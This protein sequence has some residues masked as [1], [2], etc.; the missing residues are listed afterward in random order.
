MADFSGLRQL[1]FSFNRLTDFKP[2][3]SLAGLEGLALDANR[4]EH[5]P[6]A[7]PRLKNLKY[8]SLQS[9]QLTSFSGAGFTGLVWL[10]LESNQLEKL[11]HL[12]A[13]PA[14]SELNISNNRL[15]HLPGLAGLRRLRELDASGNQLTKIGPELESLTALQDLDL[16]RNQLEEFPPA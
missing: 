12:E 1:D 5:L 11:D 6:A 10:N 4:L 8:L 9:N 13:M 16:S 14:L 3:A 2:P 15:T 7:L